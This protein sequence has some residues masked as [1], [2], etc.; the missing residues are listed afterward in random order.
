M[1]WYAVEAVSND[2]VDFSVSRMSALRLIIGLILAPW[3]SVLLCWP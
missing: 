2:Q 3:C 1:R